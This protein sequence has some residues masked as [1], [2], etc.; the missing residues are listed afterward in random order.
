MHALSSKDDVNAQHAKQSIIWKYFPSKNFILKNLG[1][2]INP[3]NHFENYFPYENSFFENRLPHA[4]ENMSRPE[5]IAEALIGLVHQTY[6]TDRVF[7]IR[8]RRHK[9]VYTIYSKQKLN[10]WIA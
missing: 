1:Y 9:H 7:P 5:H 4:V 8:P 3:D 6:R 10:T 2:A